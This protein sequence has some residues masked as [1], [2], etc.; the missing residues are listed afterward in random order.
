MA[1]GAG[2]TGLISL[3]TTDRHRRMFARPADFGKWTPRRQD[4]TFGPTSPTPESRNVQCHNTPGTALPAPWQDR[5]E[6]VGER[7]LRVGSRRVSTAS[8][9][10]PAA[11]SKFERESRGPDTAP[12][13][14]GLT[15]G[16]GTSGI[17]PEV[18]ISAGPDPLLLMIIRPASGRG[19]AERLT[20]RRRSPADG[21]ATVRRRKTWV[22]RPWEG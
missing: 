22:L 4:G 14:T 2:R 11:S 20:H 5:P 12:R 17:P 1:S 21:L 13:S 3:V 9:A 8:E 6:T 7:P 18:A 15:E 19:K 10:V 16:S